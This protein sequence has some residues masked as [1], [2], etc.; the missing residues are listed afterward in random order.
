MDVARRHPPDAAGRWFS[1]ALLLTLLTACPAPTTT[2]G[3]PA[4]TVSPAADTGR[5]ATT[6]RPDEVTG[7]QIHPIYVL[8]P[9]APDYQLDTSGAIHDALQRVNAWFIDQTGGHHLRLDTFGGKAD[10]TFHRLSA[11]VPASSD[12]APVLEHIVTRLQ[13]AGLD[14]PQKVM[15][16]L[17]GENLN[18]DWTGVGGNLTALVQVIP[19]GRWPAPQG[20]FD[21]LDKIVAHELLHALGAVPDGAPHRADGYHAGDAPH[22]VMTARADR[23]APWILDVGRDDYYGHGRSDLHDLARSYYWEPLPAHPA[24]WAGQPL[25]RIEGEAPRPLML[26]AVTSDATLE[27]APLA[28]M[29]NWRRQ[30]GEPALVPDEGLQRLLSRYLDGR[31][32]QPEANADDLRFASLYAG[33]YHVWRQHGRL[34]PGGDPA[35]LLTTMAEQA[36][37][38]GGADV[39]RTAL[40]G[41]AAVC[42]RQGDDLWLA[43][44]VGTAPFEVSGIRLG[45][46]PYGTY[47]LSGQVTIRPNGSPSLIH[48]GNE[49][50]LGYSMPLTADKRPFYVSVP[51][52]RALN[53]RIRTW[54]GTGWVGPALLTVDGRLPKETAL[55]VPGTT[56]FDKR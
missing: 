5:R 7:L 8:P 18:T 26:P 32:G 35:A 15:L 22:D 51:R 27:A 44:G 47:T 6:D 11:P 1:L 14:H 24:I 2:N 55:T 56:P 33:S 53:L 36:L 39:V 17:Y 50:E 25:T 38:N 12:S 23:H 29:A 9:D 4:T 19:A 37:A 16:I 30:A 43:I 48:I 42:R 54:D 34:A 46:G 41:M 40:T 21:G 13:E 20:T 49:T 3:Q 31:T 45:D 52:D 28:A 10:V